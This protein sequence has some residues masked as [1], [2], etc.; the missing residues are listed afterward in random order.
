MYLEHVTFQSLCNFIVFFFDPATKIGIDLGA[1]V[2][3][4]W[5]CF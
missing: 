2:L 1:Q 3:A 4:K 5:G